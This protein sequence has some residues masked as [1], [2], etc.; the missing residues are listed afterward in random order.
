MQRMRLGQR[1]V[2]LAFGLGTAVLGAAVTSVAKAPPVTVGKISSESPVP[3][4]LKQEIKT[5]MEQEIAGMDLST[6]K[7]KYVLTGSLL[8]LETKMESDRVETTC[9]ISAEL[10][11]QKG[12]R[13]E[14]VFRGKAK[15][16]DGKNSAKS[17]ELAAIKGAVKSAVQRLPEAVH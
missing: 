14:A 10:A 3:P 9:V 6:A 12:G 8:T 5:T 2:I 4:E 1:A 7:G 11:Q 17:A 16:I 15:A 13:L